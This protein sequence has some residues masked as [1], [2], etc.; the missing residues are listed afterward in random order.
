MLVAGL[1]WLM[2]ERCACTSTHMFNG[3]EVCLYLDQ[4]C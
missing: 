2:E 3:R 1:M 4:S